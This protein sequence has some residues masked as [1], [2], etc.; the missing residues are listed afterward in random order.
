MADPDRG[1]FGVT[2][3]ETLHAVQKGLVEMITH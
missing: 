3:V 1:I 2:P